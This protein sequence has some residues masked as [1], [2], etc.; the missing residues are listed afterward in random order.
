[1]IIV[2]GPDGAGKTTLVRQLTHDV[3]LQAATAVENRDRD[4]RKNPRERAYA[5]LAQAVGGGTVV[6]HDRFFWSE[7]IYG[8]VL[9]GESQFSVV[10]Q[11]RMMNLLK[12]M[13]CPIFFCLPPY[14][15]TVPALKENPPQLEGWDQEKAYQIWELY[16][17]AM[18]VAANRI[19]SVWGYDYTGY[20]T[21]P[22]GNGRNLHTNVFL[23]Y[24][25][26]KKYVE[27]Y[28]KERREWTI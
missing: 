9:R 21:Q 20:F 2:E 26:V 1:M 5:G 10:E 4:L 12:G 7:L 11:F 22:D 25:Q 13:R 27:D 24:D 18:Q 19:D 28:L 8:K 3:G 17:S 23:D 14:E 6:V 15:K 16:Q